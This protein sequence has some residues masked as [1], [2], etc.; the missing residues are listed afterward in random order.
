MVEAGGSVSYEGQ[1]GLVPK[2]TSV[3]IERNNSE[4][5]HMLSIRDSPDLC[6]WPASTEIPHGPPLLQHFPYS[7]ARILVLE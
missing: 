3:Q 5:L 4:C 6:I 1:R 2:V 7:E